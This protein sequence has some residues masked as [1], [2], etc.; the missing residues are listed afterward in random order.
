MKSNLYHRRWAPPDGRAARRR[1][2]YL[3]H[4]ISEHSGRYDRLANWLTEHGWHVGSHDHHGFGQS[5]G[6]QGLLRSA[7]AY[8]EDTASALARFSSE[9]DDNP[10]LFGHSMGGVIAAATVLNGRATVEGLVLS[11]PAFTPALSGWQ[12]LQLSLMNRAAPNLVLDRS[13]DARKLSH[14]P[15]V[16]DGYRN[17]PLV[18]GRVSARLVQWIVDTGQQCIQRASQLTV[19]TLVVAGDADPV[20]HAAG[21]HQFTAAVPASFL[22][23]H[24]YSGYR[25]EVFNED[26]ERRGQPLADLRDWLTQL[27]HVASPD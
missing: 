3:V 8:V 21:I 15:V 12:R 14:D 9:L 7:D 5:S 11:S 6:T 23:E 19:P 27:N 13:L 18:H 25:H 1:G 20:I 4:G 16:V 24:W 26:A 2:V 22:T 10:V 17:D